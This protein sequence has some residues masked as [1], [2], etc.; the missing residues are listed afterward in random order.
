MAAFDMSTDSSSRK[1]TDGGHQ[2]A[3]GRHRVAFAR[4]AELAEGSAR[5]RMPRRAAPSGRTRDVRVDWQLEVRLRRASGGTPV[6]RY[7]VQVVAP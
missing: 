3:L 6:D 4:G 1:L 7:V 5:F 2:Q